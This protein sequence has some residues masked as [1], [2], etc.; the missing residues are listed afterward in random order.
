MLDPSNPALDGVASL[1]LDGAARSDRWGGSGCHVRVGQQRVGRVP[2][3]GCTGAT[4][5]R[6]PNGLSVAVDGN[7]CL[8]SDTNADVGGMPR[9]GVVHLFMFD[10]S[11]WEYDRSLWPPD[12]RSGQIFGQPPSAMDGGRQLLRSL[13]GVY[14]MEGSVAL[15]PYCVCSSGARC[16]NISL[17]EGCRNSTAFG[18]RI[19]VCGSTRIETD[20]L[21]LTATNVP[22]NQSGLF[23]MGGNSQN[24]APFGDGQ[25]CVSGGSAGIYR[26]PLRNAG[27][28]GQIVEGPGIVEL[29]ETQFSSGGQIQAGDTW[30]FQCWYRDPRLSAVTA[31]TF[32]TRL[33]LPSLRS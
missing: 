17:D 11:S 13:R 10:G 12:L 9:G 33:R 8:V 19:E 32:R 1:D 4:H 16:L 28:A 22:Q 24:A 23:F 25:R 21:V 5:R 30:F 3:T 7:R 6:A 14:V 15:A 20:D 29:S 18:S 2:R 27:N 26:F 31:S